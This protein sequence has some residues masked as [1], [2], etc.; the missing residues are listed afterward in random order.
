MLEH[1][2]ITIVLK[3]I[4]EVVDFRAFEQFASVILCACLLEFTLDIGVEL[5]IVDRIRTI[6]LLE[7][8][9]TRCCKGKSVL[10]HA[11][12]IDRLVW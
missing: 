4:Y 6:F 9:V 12:S 1:I 7:Q 3:I 8:I 5:R 2:F 11:T 10:I